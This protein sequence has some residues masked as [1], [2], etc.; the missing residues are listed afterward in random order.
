MRH[1]LILGLLCAAAAAQAQTTTTY[2]IGPASG[3]IAIDGEIRDDEWA[4]ASPIDLAYETS[5]GN[6]TPA[7]VKTQALL[8]YDQS[9]F[10]V[11]FR[12]WDP[13]LRAI[14]AN[15]TDRDRAFQ[16]DFVGIVVDTFNDGR[17]A[18]EFFVNP[19]GVQMDLTNTDQD[20]GN[21]DDSW[22]AIWESAGRIHADRWEV[23]LAIPFSTLRFRAADGAQT[24]GL[25][26]L[27]IYP[28]D[29]RYRLGLNA[30]DQN[31]S[32]YICQFAKLTGFTGIKPGTNLELD[33]TVTSSRTD[34]RA[35]FPPAPM[36]EG[37]FDTEPGITGRWGVTSGVMLNATLNPDFSQVEADAPQ[38]DVN[39]TFTLSFPEKRPFFLEGI[40]FFQSPIQAVYTRT[41]ADP[42]WGG[43]VT[44]KEGKSGGG[45]Y[46]AGDAITGVI[47]PGSERSSETVL[48]GENVAAVLRYRY[49]LGKDSTL[50]LLVTS[51]NG[52]DYANHVGGVD[53]YFRLGSSDSIS[54]Q[55]LTSQTKYPDA[56]ARAFGQPEGSFGDLAGRFFYRHDTRNWYWKASYDDL[57]TDF[58][59][60]SGFLPRVDIKY[61]D[62]GTQR[63]W[64]PEKHPFFS[65]F[66][67]GGDWD[68]TENQQG[69]L[70]EE[71]FETWFGF[72]GAKQSHLE[73]DIGRRRRSFLG[74]Q[75]GP[76]Q[77]VN[78][79]GEVAPTKRFYGELQINVGDTIDFANVRPATR[80]RVAPFLRYRATRNL[81]LDLLYDRERLDVEGGQLYD[82]AVSQLKAV[83]Q[84]NLRTFLR[85][86]VQ[87]S[88]I[89]RNKDLYNFPVN[90]RS[91]R[92]FP[93]F[94]FSYKLNPQTVLFVGYSSTG[95]S[96]DQTVDVVETT[97]SFFVKIGYAWLL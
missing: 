51:R 14:R 94:L 36:S 85:A 19:L 9:T 26:L 32:C 13:D 17:R 74:T 47:F 70:L 61:M 12:V 64:W 37:D 73:F 56:I 3:K 50:G 82:A 66:W 54:A 16:D 22:D 49:D 79:Y 15:M 20:G 43:K 69:T 30:L 18:F 84:F 41:I 62:A 21:E 10:Y 93:Q 92:V 78:I 60:D 42:D 29:R 88:D 71:E 81:T 1:W 25:D 33:P 27:R 53:G 67:I 91:R 68:R 76:E 34:A 63:M 7:Q 2:A 86:I 44:G 4:G 96:N 89:E 87:Y 31:R 48:P 24:W 58:R 97:R 28:R 52:E 59:A 45:A 77:F 95:L 57:G 55:L 72:Q 75:F 40:D 35:L 5:P 11:A 46:V 39:N 23:E 65:R 80:V 90:A 6:N 83:Y 8:A 38:L